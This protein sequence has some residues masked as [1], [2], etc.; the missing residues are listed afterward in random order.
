MGKAEETRQAIIKKAAV[1]FNKNGYQRTSMSTLTKALNLT[2]GA[3]YGNFAD[4]DDLAVEAFRYSIGQVYNRILPRLESYESPLGK[5]RALARTFVDFFE[6]TEK[7]GGCPILNTAVDSDDAHPKLLQE[8]RAA[9]E[10]WKEN[11]IRLVRAGM[12]CGEIRTDADAEAFAANFIALIEGGILLAKTMGDRNY[13]E[14]SVD[15]IDLLIDYL[16][17][18]AE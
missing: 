15:A 16:L 6:E 3:I 2:K 5:L 8:V 4:K 12:E 13:L 14:H 9:L 7:S 17:A 11:M 10:D 1:I 18:V